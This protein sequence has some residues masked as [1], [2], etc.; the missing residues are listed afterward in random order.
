[1]PETKLIPTAT[2]LDVISNVITIFTEFLSG[3]PN[4]INAFIAEIVAT[5]NN[6]PYIEGDLVI[7]MVNSPESIDY[8]IDSNG[9]LIVNTSAAANDADRYSIDSSGDLIYTTP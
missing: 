6:I 7:T 5:K 2:T 8:V 4:T 9:N 3:L 1:M